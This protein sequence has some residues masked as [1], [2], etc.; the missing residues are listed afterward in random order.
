MFKLTCSCMILVV[1]LSMFYSNKVD[2]RVTF[3]VSN[4]FFSSLLKF[5]FFSS[6]IWKVSWLLKCFILVWVDNERSVDITPMM[7][8]E[9]N[10]SNEKA[11]CSYHYTVCR[12]LWW[13]NAVR[14]K[15]PG[16]S[17]IIPLVRWMVQIQ[18]CLFSH[19]VFC[20]VRQ[21]KKIH[22]SYIFFP[23]SASSSSLFLFQTK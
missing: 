4:S 5:M 10:I 18:I 13:I 14:I 19:I 22:H 15:S 23:L 7:K 20:V 17:T 16:M 12:I 9:D 11:I 3:E 21:V 8:K 6:R 1:L 2:G